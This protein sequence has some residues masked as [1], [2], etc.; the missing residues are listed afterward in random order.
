VA[1][2]LIF[3]VIDKERINRFPTL[4]PTSLIL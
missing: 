2:W 1:L 4:Y 3:Q